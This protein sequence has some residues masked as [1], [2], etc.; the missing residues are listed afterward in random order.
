M[1]VIIL[2]LCL[3]SF[4]IRADYAP[5]RL[6]LM[7]LSAD[8]I[9][10]GEITDLRENDYTLKISASATN[11]IGTIKINRFKDWPCATRWAKYEKGQMVIVFLEKRENAYHIMSGDGEGEIEVKNNTVMI[12]G[13][14]MD[15]EV[16]N[17]KSG[18]K[19]N[20]FIKAIIYIR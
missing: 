9:V 1:K 10:F 16:S 5:Q 17:I 13:Q 6:W 11:D 18:L 8:K 14:I 2:S 4:S 20:D 19:T 7:A 15:C 3:I 12:E